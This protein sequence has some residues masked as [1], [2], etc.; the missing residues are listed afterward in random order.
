M[1]AKNPDFAKRGSRAE[2]GGTGGPEESAGTEAARTET[3]DREADERAASVD[4]EAEERSGSDEGAV[5]VP[6]VP[7]SDR[8]G[9]GSGSNGGREGAP[10]DGRAPVLEEILGIVKVIEQRTGQPKRGS[11]GPGKAAID[12]LAKSVEELGRRGA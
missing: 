11:A 10:Q 6:S 1:T 2:G 4:G 9:E 3:S 12:K 8:S 5:E 7:V